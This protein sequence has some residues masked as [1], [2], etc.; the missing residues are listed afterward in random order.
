MK[1]PPE[2]AAMAPFL[3]GWLAMAVMQHKNEPNP[4]MDI[5]EVV[6]ETDEEGNYYP[7][8]IV[9]FKSGATVAVTVEMTDPD[10]DVR[11]AIRSIRGG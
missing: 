11:A 1:F 5:S 2:Q 9:K 10:A 7:T 6:I 4:L 8:F 3:E